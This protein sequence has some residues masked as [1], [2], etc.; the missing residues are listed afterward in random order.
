MSTRTGGPGLVFGKPSLSRLP[1]PTCSKEEGKPVDTL[2]KWGRCNHCGHQYG[3]GTRKGP[4]RW[5]HG[6]P[7]VVCPDPQP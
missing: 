4:K 7:S 5:S 2:H 6:H 1:C 3:T